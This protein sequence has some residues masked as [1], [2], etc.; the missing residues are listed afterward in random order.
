MKF[1]PDT[2]QKSQP[3]TSKK[4]LNHRYSLRMKEGGKFRHR[5]DGSQ[6]SERLTVSVVLS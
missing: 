6:W 3:P 5:R 2:V 1:V 4:R